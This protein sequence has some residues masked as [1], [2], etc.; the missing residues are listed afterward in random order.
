[1][2]SASP[3][4]PQTPPRSE[5]DDIAVATSS[6]VLERNIRALRAR[7]EETDAKV[8]WEERLAGRI[9]A[10]TGRMLFVYIH[11]VVFE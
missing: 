11:V 7:A 1:M 6:T 3:H 2:T 8:G 10:F 5:G 4:T 9:T